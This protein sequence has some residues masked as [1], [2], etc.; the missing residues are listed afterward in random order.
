MGQENTTPA[1]RKRRMLRALIRKTLFLL[2][3]RGKRSL[4][5][6]RLGGALLE[7]VHA[8]CRV[9]EFLLTSVKWMTHVTDADDDGRLGGTGLD[10]VAARATDFR[11]HI[12]RMNVCFHKR[13]HKIP[14]AGWITS[15][16]FGVF[17]FNTPQI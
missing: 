9:H 1:V 4:G 3:L 12:L 6:L 14:P 5:G 2:F 16:K 13:P 17:R 10:H 8:T 11:I 15:G 7:L